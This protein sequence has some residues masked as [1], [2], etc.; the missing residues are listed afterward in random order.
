MSM[1][2]QHNNVME[3]PIVCMMTYDI[4]PDCLRV[5]YPAGSCRCAS[6]EIGGTVT[7]GFE[8]ILG[9]AGAYC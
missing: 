9:C 2:L 8:L 1:S 3:H 4:K 6:S 5:G 7:A